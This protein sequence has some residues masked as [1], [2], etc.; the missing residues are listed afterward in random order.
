MPSDLQFHQVINYYTQTE[1]SKRLTRLESELELLRTRDILSR[2]LPVP[3]AI[4]LDIGG[5]PAVHSHWLAE[6]GYL[7]HLVD[8]VPTH[9]HIAETLD[10][11][12]EHKLQSIQLGDACKL[13]FESEGANGVVMLGPLYHLLKRTDRIKALQEAYRV[14]RPGGI[15]LA[16]AISRYIPMVKVLTR[17]LLDQRSMSI[18]AQTAISGQHR[19]DPDQDFFT[20]AFFHHPSG[21]ERELKQAGFQP[22]V[23]LAVEGPARLLGEQFKERWSHPETQKWLLEMTRSMEADRALL[24][25]SG[26]MISVAR[27]QA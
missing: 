21:L 25:V 12:Q 16:G 5:G 4:I 13:N 9:I 3:P 24:G 14:L 8:I 11:Q 10:I 6:R 15:L 18:A 20:T 1:E 26:H 27:K 19:P 17:N 23:T 2:W 22:Q 7:V